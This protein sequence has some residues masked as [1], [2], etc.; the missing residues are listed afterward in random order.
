MHILILDKLNLCKMNNIL[1]F[2]LVLLAV[3]YVNGQVVFSAAKIITSDNLKG[4]RA[5]Y[6]ADI[7]GDGYPDILSASLSDNKVAWY[8]NIDGAGNFGEQQI[9]TNGAIGANA[10]IAADLDGDN[11]LD[12][13]SASSFDGKIAW[14][15]NTDGTGTFG[16]QQVISSQCL[17]A[18]S[19]A[20]ADIDND[21]DLDVVS[22]SLSD[23]KIAWYENTDGLGTFGEQQIISTQADAALF[24]KTADINNDG[25]IDVVSASLLDSKVAWYENNNGSFSEQKIIT[26][27]LNQPR[28]VYC[29]DIDNDGDV[30][31]FVASSGDNTVSWYEN[32]DAKGTFSTK[33]EIANDVVGATSVICSDLD[34]DGDLD[35]V[36]CSYN[37]NIVMWYENTDGLGNFGSRN[38]IS[39][40]ASGP[41]QLWI[42]NL[43]GDDK[44]DVMV[45]CEIGNN[46]IWYQNETKTAVEDVKDEVTCKLYPQPVVDV[47]HIDSEQENIKKI[48]VFDMFGKPIKS[49]HQQQNGVNIDMSNLPK[50]IYFIEIHTDKRRFVREI[51]KL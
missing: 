24:V 25:S 44:Q 6:A 51:I 40:I 26:D 30:D 29:A 33:K 35:V 1:S 50:G 11:D 16:A 22:A 19:V 48:Y 27:S 37:K 18:M 42:A 28:A 39:N 32:T 20:T 41:N 9:I 45:A 36:S 34:L 10:V 46:L 47:L 7:D 14:Y 8:K 12:V 4:P 2:L 3:G 31:I 21:G 5:I 49:L 43:N 15:A 13:L 23:D 17:Y 38:E